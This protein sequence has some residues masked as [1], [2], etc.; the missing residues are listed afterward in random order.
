MNKKNIK[1]GAKTIEVTNELLQKPSIKM[2]KNINR[3]KTVTTP[4]KYL[5]KKLKI[6]GNNKH[7]N[8]SISILENEVKKNIFN[9][10][11]TTTNIKLYD[12]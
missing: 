12:A 9:R 3:T 4:N 8:Y 6:K 2:K 7:K 10:V 5:T 11:S 1:L